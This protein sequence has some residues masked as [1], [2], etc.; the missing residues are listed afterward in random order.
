MRL[1]VRKVNAWAGAGDLAQQ[2]VA[3]I[4][5]EEKDAVH[6]GWR[7]PERGAGA[8]FA[9]RQVRAEHRRPCP[10]VVDAAF[11]MMEAGADAAD[12]AQPLMIRAVEPHHGAH[13]AQLVGGVVQ[14]SESGVIR[15]RLQA[16]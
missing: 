16:P 3:G 1:R 13:R 11:A 14:S 12:S 8:E 10:N 6:R 15:R 7:K 9:E 4:S 2:V 5:V